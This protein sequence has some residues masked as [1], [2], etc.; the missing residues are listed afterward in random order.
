MPVR[1]PYLLIV[2][3]TLSI[4]TKSIEIRCYAGLKYVVGQEVIQDTENC[5][6]ILGM[7]ESYCYKF[8]EETSLNEVVKMG[9]SSFFCNGIRNRCMET[10]LLG[11]KG[12]LCCCNDRHYCNSESLHFSIFFVFLLVTLLL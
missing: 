6:A 11:M 3:I 12:K 5:D 2:L 8:M 7:G 10:D 9:C 1:L 4:V